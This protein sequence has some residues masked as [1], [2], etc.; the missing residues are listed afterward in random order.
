MTASAWS[1]HYPFVSVL[2]IGRIVP[3][4]ARVIHKGCIHFVGLSK[5][6]D[7]VE[8]CARFAGV[9]CIQHPSCNLKKI[10][11]H[12]ENFLIHYQTAEKSWWLSKKP[13]RQLNLEITSQ[14]YEDYNFTQ[15]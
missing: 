5:L 13:I 8:G 14:A 6:L 7:T 1:V 15:F 10:M 12:D 9:L 4:S 3:G 11:H 2:C